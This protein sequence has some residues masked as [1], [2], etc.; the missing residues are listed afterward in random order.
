MQS[1]IHAHCWWQVTQCP[2]GPSHLTDS[3]LLLLGT[4]HPVHYG[5][6]V[7]LGAVHMC[8]GCGVRVV[9]CGSA[10]C[11]WGQHCAESRKKQRQMPS[12][13]T[14]RSSM[15]CILLQCHS[16]CKLFLF[17]SIFLS[18][19]PGELYILAGQFA[20]SDE[21]VCKHGLDITL[22]LYPRCVWDE[23]YGTNCDS[24]DYCFLPA[25]NCSWSADWYNCQSWDFRDVQNVLNG[26]L[27]LSLPLPY[28][29]GDCMQPILTLK[30]SVIIIFYRLTYVKCCHFTV[31][32]KT[33]WLSSREVL[34][35]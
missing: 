11:F 32:R 27:C 30:K 8:Q 7:E 25:L 13:T 31:G 21:R 5:I 29:K 16:L 14:Q 28:E 9:S 2:L 15:G 19:S 18:S 12:V 24:G 23:R 34:R 26:N 22:S 20:V 33:S 4:Q 3:E 17:I 35:Y 1:G 6:L 10:I